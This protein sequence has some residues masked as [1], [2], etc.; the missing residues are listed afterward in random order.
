[1]TKFSVH[2]CKN[3]DELF[4][5]QQHIVRPFNRCL[6]AGNFVDGLD[7]SDCSQQRAFRRLLRQERRLQDN[8]E[9]DALRIRRNPAARQTALA[10]ALLLSNDQQ[11]VLAA[12]VRQKLRQIVARIYGITIADVA[13]QPLRLQM[14]Q[15][16]LREQTVRSLTQ[17]IAALRHRLNIIAL[18]LQ[19]LDVLPDSCTRNLQLTGNLLARQRLRAAFS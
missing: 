8:G 5:Q 3:A 12:L 18:V 4:A 17:N 9:P 11:T 14:R 1:M 19:G 10:C 13:A 2:L 6:Y 16:L 15:N 7:Y